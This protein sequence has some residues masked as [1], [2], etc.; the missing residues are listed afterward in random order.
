[1]YIYIYIYIY[2]QRERDIL[3]I[4]CLFYIL[5]QLLM[6]KSSMVAMNVPQTVLALEGFLIVFEE[7]FWIPRIPRDR[8]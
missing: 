8:A 1:M 4:F 6:I 5:R 7:I 2:I 3:F